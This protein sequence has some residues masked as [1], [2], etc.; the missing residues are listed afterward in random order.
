T[1]TA[2]PGAVLDS[3][4][5]QFSTTP[6]YPS[7]QQ[8]G[9]S[10]PPYVA[11]GLEN[12]GFNYFHNEF[13]FGGWHSWPTVDYAA[14]HGFKVVD[15]YWRNPDTYWTGSW[16]NGNWLPAQTQWMGAVGMDWTAMAAGVGIAGNSWDD[17]RWDQAIDAGE[18]ALIQAVVGH[19]PN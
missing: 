6:S 16:T 3:N 19:N 9:V 1:A 17:M 2:L 12:F 13:N 5:P 7:W 8:D 4:P 15:S 14:L 10:T 11:S 18:P